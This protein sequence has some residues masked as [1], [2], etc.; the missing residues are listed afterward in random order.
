M[1]F[2]L[3]NGRTELEKNSLLVVD[4]A[5]MIGND[6]FKEL[7]RVAA[8][9]K[10]NVII[11][12]DEKQIASVQRGGMFEVF[13]GEYGSKAMLNIQRQDSQW[14][15]SVAMAFSSGEVRTGVEIL[16]EQNCIVSSPDKITNMEKLL[17]DWHESSE[18]LDNK[19]I[20]AV[21]NKDVDSLNHGAREYLK[22]NNILKGNEIAIGGHHYMQGDRILIRQTNK[23]IGVTNGDIAI[24]MHVSKDQFVIKDASGKEIE[25]N[26]KE[27]SGFRHGYATTVFKAQG[28][29]INDVFVLHDGFAGLR[30]SYVALSRNI[31]CLKLYINEEATRSTE[32]LIKQLSSDPEIS[33][34]MS[35]QIKKDINKKYLE[36]VFEPEKGTF[37]S[38]LDSAMGY[39]RKKV[40]EYSDKRILSTEYYSYKAP[41]IKQERV[42]LVLDNIGREAESCAVGSFT[43]TSLLSV[44]GGS[45]V[46]NNAVSAAINSN[47]GDD[48]RATGNNSN[49]QSKTKQTGKERFYAKADY[50]RKSNNANVQKTN[51]D[52]ENEKL[53]SEVKF[54]AEQIVKDL[55]GGANKSLS[56]GRTL[57]FG[58][59]GSLAVRIS[60]ERAGHW[61]D[62]SADKGGDLFTLVQ[63]KQ[64]CDFKEAAEY[65]RKVVGM[66]SGN[67][68]LQLVHDHRNSEVT[69]EYIKSVKQEKRYD[70]QK[71]EYVGKLHERAK[72]IGDKSVAH[73]YLSAQRGIECDLGN[74]LKTAG[75]FSKEKDA[76]LPALVAFARDSEGNVIGGQKIL[77]NKRSG[78][79][80]EIAVPKQSFGRISGAFVDLGTINTDGSNNSS[81]KESIV[82][83]KNG[84][85]D[86]EN[87]HSI[88]ITRTMYKKRTA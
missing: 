86:K 69:K 44:V 67:H 32:H 5:G 4:E 42:E 54:K 80:A 41:E 8:G 73:K 39:A 74:D 72:D 10:C 26:P 85:T 51:W 87:G 7:L 3:Y 11:S 18:S 59:K 83:A 50:A 48:V 40:T 2:K 27:Y 23:D 16:K 6:D 63:D 21:K 61:Y 29:S 82:L 30:N 68:N 43:E 13:A 1:L 31:K 52:Q 75:I 17:Q 35:Y 38:M 15:K 28:A 19:L 60:G 57:R 22:A 84:S 34:S 45:Y 88:T 49:V 9:R 14:G 66:E 78:S 55:L 25:F 70:L 53:R 46:D 79:K 20:I 12:G 24:I 76:Y 64:A 65:L 37:L 62:F 36:S 33:S 56:N 58:E 71:Q 77:L 81:H 47:S